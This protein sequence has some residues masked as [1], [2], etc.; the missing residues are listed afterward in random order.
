MFRRFHTNPYPTAKFTPSSTRTVWG[1]AVTDGWFKQNKSICPN[2]ARYR[3]LHRWYSRHS[4][5]PVLLRMCKGICRITKH[6]NL[7]FVLFCL[8]LLSTLLKWSCCSTYV[9]TL[10][11]LTY[12]EFKSCKGV[13]IIMFFLFLTATQGLNY[14]ETWTRLAVSYMK[15]NMLRRKTCPPIFI[16]IIYEHFMD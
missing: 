15:G 13:S 3:N 16:T 4:P 1:K 6:T 10:T 7:A 9:P 14:V 8:Y 2:L 11:P 5:V 12:T